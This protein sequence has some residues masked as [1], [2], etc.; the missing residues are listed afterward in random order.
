MESRHPLETRIGHVFRNPDLL[1]TALIHPSARYEFNLPEDNQRLEYLGDAVL[2]LV[3]AHHLY[4]I[5]ADD[6]EGALTIKRSAMAGTVPLARLARRMGLGEF[7]VFGRGEAN[8]GGCEKA[9]NLA[10]ALEALIGAVYL[11]GGLEAAWRVF[12]HLFLA[13]TGDISAADGHDNPK[14]RLQ[15]WAQR[16]GWPVPV[17][18]IIGEEGP[19]HLRRFTVAVAIADQGGATATAGSKRAAEAEAA[20][21]LLGKLETPSN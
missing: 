8:G 14:G 20:R 5:K 2:G 12:E 17:Y 1:Q 21:L 13:D 19:A 3:T 15:E 16:H 6:D 18:T 11:D 4:A 10:D 9:G 7:L